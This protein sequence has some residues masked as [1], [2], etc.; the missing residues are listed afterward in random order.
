MSDSSDEDEYE[1][2]DETL[3]RIKRNDSCVDKIDL[4]GV[5]IQNM[6]NEQ[7]DELGRDIADNTH[8]VEVNLSDAAINDHKASRLFRG[9]TRSSSIKEMTLRYDDLSAAGVLSME[10]F[11]QNANNLQLLSLSNNNIQSGGFNMIF[12]AL[13][14][15]PIETLFCRW[16][17][18]ESIEIEKEN[19]PR[20]LRQ[21]AL[22]GNSINTDGCRQIA[23]LL[24]GGDVTLKS[25][26]LEGNKIDDEGVEIL[27]DALQNNKS[28][29]DLD[30]KGNKRISKHGNIMLLKLVNDVS[31][32]EATLRSNHTL[33]YLRGSDHQ[34]QIH[35]NNLITMNRNGGSTEAAGREKVIQTQL[36]SAMRAKLEEIQGINHSLYREIDPLHLPEVLALVGRRHGQ[37][38]LY[39]ALKSS[40]AGVISTVN[41]KE[42]IEVQMAYHVSKLEH[43]ASKL[44]Q[45][46]AELSAIEAA[47]GRAEGGESRSSKRRRKWWWGLWGRTS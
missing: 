7:L 23:K 47:Q 22:Q 3:Q 8:L 13:R 36:N 28:L 1:S 18:I 14:D 21:L 19:S 16:C 42:C 39:I 20:H 25:L 26:N 12:R 15:S 40:I 2:W 31:S 46:D 43:H 38:E 4:D 41:R 5:D 29:K 27:V 37:G 10:P 45:L 32:I 30:L 9:L 24:Q 44:E 33:W 11:L 35:I 6:T 17:G 34:I